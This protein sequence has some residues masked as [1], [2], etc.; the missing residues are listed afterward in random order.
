MIWPVIFDLFDDGI[1]GGHG[2]VFAGGGR[3]QPAFRNAVEALYLG[4]FSQ[5]GK[6]IVLASRSAR[7]FLLAE[8]EEY[9]QGHNNNTKY[10]HGKSR[11]EVKMGK[12]W[13][14]S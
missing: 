4:L 12:I 14:A 2:L 13:S 5:I 1:F 9:T 3:V 7:G 8:R 6:A 11:S 10:V